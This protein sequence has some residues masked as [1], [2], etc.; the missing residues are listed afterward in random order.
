MI[1]NLRPVA[2]L[3][4]AAEVVR[5]ARPKVQIASSGQTDCSRPTAEAVAGQRAQIGAGSA[6]TLIQE[7]GPGRKAR[8]KA[9][10][11]LTAARIVLSTIS[12]AIYIVSGRVLTGV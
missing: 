3:T 2:S 8:P 7:S 6:A 11:Q 12:S 5:R 10:W 4:V 9:G 1:P